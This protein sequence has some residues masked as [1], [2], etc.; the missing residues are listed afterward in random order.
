METQEIELIA[1]KL[2]LQNAYKY[3]KAPQ[4]G[5]VMGKLLGTHPE[6]KAQAKELMPVINK[7]LADVGKMPPEDVREKLQSMAPELI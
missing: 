1:Q 3:G 6:L 5:A 2:A 4:A 7:V